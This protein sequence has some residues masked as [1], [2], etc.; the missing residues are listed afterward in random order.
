[1]ITTTTL[2]IKPKVLERMEEKGEIE[3]RDGMWS[4]LIN[5]YYKY[6]YIGELS[7]IK[8]E[9]PTCNLCSEKRGCGSAYSRKIW[10]KFFLINAS[11]LLKSIVD[12]Y[13][14]S[15][16]IAMGAPIDIDSLKEGNEE[17]FNLLKEFYTL[18]TDLTK[19]KVSDLESFFD[20]H[21]IDTSVK[22]LE[23]IADYFYNELKDE[24]KEK[25]PELNI[26]KKL[27]KASSK[28]SKS[29]SVL[30][31]VLSG[32]LLF[33]PHDELY[34]EEECEEEYE[35][36]REEEIRPFVDI[37]SLIGL[38]SAK[39]QI[40]ALK[41]QFAYR[42]KMK[43]YFKFDNDM[44]HTAFVGNPGVGKT[45]LAQV[46][47][48]CLYSLGYI[49]TN[50]VTYAKKSDLIAEHIGGTAPATQRVI[51]KSLGGVL[52]IDEAY[53]LIPM[54]EKDF[55]R[56]CITTLLDNM[57]SKKDD[58]VIIFAGYPKE[59]KKLLDVN[60][61]LKSRVPNIIHFEDYTNEEIL[62]I[63]KLKLDSYKVNRDSDIEYKITDSLA[64]KIISILDNER[65]S[66]KFGNARF[67]ENLLS[68]IMKEHSQYCISN[69]IEDMNELTLLTDR[70]L[71]NYKDDIKK[72]ENVMSGII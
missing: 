22:M 65:K 6:S 23:Q 37:D 17:V 39:K 58:L 40:N 1:M 68:I 18:T 42:K 52:F 61:G 35:E 9:I 21:S 24:L 20:S 69:E 4:C 38:T 45:M 55:S 14:T 41:N 72:I 36:E 54:G 53:E 34:D 2:E 26:N 71:N 5:E 60:D 16:E 10:N 56:E 67:G 33:N 49:K 50:R 48:D 15:A 28:S 27:K 12:K 29:S 62:S 7:K 59:I 46:Y 3:P 44:M 19:D 25:Y 30:S 57:T 13:Y 11:C 31:S 8:S 51:N 70:Y 63:M 47:A 64:S 43:K 32:N 66:N